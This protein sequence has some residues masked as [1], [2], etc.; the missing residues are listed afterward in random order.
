MANKIEF[1]EKESKTTERAYLAPEIVRQRVRTLEMLSPRVGECILDVGCG[2]GLLVY[3]LA[4]EVGLAGRVV[5]I[6]TGGPRLKLVEQRCAGLLHVEFAEGDATALAAD[7][8]TFDAVA[9]VQV[10]L[11]TKDFENAL[12]EIH[13]VLK[14]SG[15]VAI[16]ETDWRGAVLSHPNPRLTQK[17]MAAWD[18]SVASP[19]LPA[20][21]GLLL[22]QHGFTAPRIEAVPILTTA[23]LPEGYSVG[24]MA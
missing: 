6:D 16:T 9:C 15:R 20:R 17:M 1:D 7:G 2:P 10:L 18:Q 4:A 22:H 5:G 12:A 19:N 24:M 8:A 13:R 14:P 21:L 23:Y 3:D 11:Y